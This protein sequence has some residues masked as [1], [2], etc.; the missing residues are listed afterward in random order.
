MALQRYSTG[1]IKKNDTSSVTAILQSLFLKAN[2]RRNRVRSILVD[3]WILHPH[4]IQYDLFDQ[5]ER[6]SS[7]LSKKVEIIRNKYGNGIIQ[8]CDVF[9]ALKH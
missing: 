9:R 5:A 4:S 7:D 1:S 2:Q 3:V 6:R 8:T